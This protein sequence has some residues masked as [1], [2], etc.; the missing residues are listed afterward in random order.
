[1]NLL[2]GA[3]GWVFGGLLLAALILFQPLIGLGFADG[4]ILLAGLAL[5]LALPCDLAGLGIIRY[6]AARNQAAEAARQAL[7]Q[8]PNLDAATL[9]RLTGESNALPPGRRAAMDSSLALALY[10]SIIFTLIGAFFAFWH[11]SWAVAILFL[12]ACVGGVL[13]LLRVVSAS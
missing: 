2:D 13:L 4:A 9:V 7:G 11:L 5:A 10:L 1:M 12:L 3:G 8:N 6:V